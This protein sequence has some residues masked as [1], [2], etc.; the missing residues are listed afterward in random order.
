MSFVIDPF[1]C[2]AG[3]N[4][5]SFGENVK[6]SIVTNVGVLRR[7]RSERQHCA[8]DRTQ[9]HRNGPRRDW[10]KSSRCGAQ[11]T[12]RY[13]M[14][15]S[16]I[17]RPASCRRSLA[18]YTL[19]HGDGGKPSTVR[20]CRRDNNRTGEGALPGAGC[21]K[22]VDSAVWKVMLPSTFWAS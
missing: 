8:N 7:Y 20:S 9:N 11:M 10:G 15:K 13:C 14:S 4:V 6:L 21:G 2:R 17:N 19:H 16:P 12:F 1:D 18:A 22:A 5:N 3:G